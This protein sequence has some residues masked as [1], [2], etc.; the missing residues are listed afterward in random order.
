MRERNRLRQVLEAT[1]DIWDRPDTR[2]A[3]RENCWKVLE[4][5]T[6]A[7]GSEVYA[8]DT[9]EKHCYHRC[10]SRFCSLLSISMWPSSI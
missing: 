1:R 8:S 3:F 5:G 6:P 9:E 7:L 4:C 2:L 10:K